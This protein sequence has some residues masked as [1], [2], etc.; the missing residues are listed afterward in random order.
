MAT[1][2]GASTWSSN[3]WGGSQ[4]A[5]TGTAASGFVGAPGVS[6]TVNITGVSAT[7][8]VASVIYSIPLTG[9][10]ARGDV[11]NVTTT[12]AP[13]LS[14]NTASGIVGNVESNLTVALTG[15][16]ATGVVGTVEVGPHIFPLTGVSSTGDVETLDVVIFRDTSGVSASAAVQSIAASSRLVAITGCPAMGNVG[17]V[18][19][20]YWSVIDTAETPNWVEVVTD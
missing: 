1:G 13:T 16:F 20:R 6:V 3:T 18:G 12:V 7:G 19:Y 14:S 9:V 11:G 10:S 15:A 8:S 4:D 17:D 2:W 5:L